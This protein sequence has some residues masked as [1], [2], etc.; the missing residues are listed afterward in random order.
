MSQL[1]QIN[2]KKFNL[3]EYLKNPARKVITGDGRNVRIICTDAKSSR[4]HTVVT[5]VE[6]SNGSESIA[7]YTPD[8]Q[9]FAWVSSDTEDLYF[10]PERHEGWVN[11]YADTKD[12]SYTSGVCIY[13]TKEEQIADIGKAIRKLED[14][15]SK[16]REL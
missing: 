13:D 6:E 15:K 12:N 2:M 9:F 3:D 14:K 10:V 1:K 11:I 4:T 5:L 8:G 7:S 16:L